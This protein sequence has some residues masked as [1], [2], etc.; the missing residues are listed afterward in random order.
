MADIADN[1]SQIV[2]ISRTGSQAVVYQKKRVSLG[3][4]D[5]TFNGTNLGYTHKGEH[6]K[7][8]IKFKVVQYFTNEYGDTPVEEKY[9]G[10]TSK[11]GAS[12]LS[13]GE[14][15]ASLLGVSGDIDKSFIGKSTVKGVLEIQPVDGTEDDK[16]VFY[17]ASCNVAYSGEANAEGKAKIVVV[18]NALPDAQGKIINLF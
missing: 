14:L 8:D 6:A 1:Y 9:S 3:I 11:L 7:L 16:I 17:N 13:D 4:C 15:F 2:S 12:F 5:I 10:I 18:F